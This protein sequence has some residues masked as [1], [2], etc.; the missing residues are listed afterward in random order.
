MKAETLNNIGTDTR[1][2]T[3][4]EVLHSSSFLGRRSEG[5]YHG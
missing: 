5:F 3:L 1:I 4:L 2:T